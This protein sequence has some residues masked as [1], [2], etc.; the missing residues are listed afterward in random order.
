MLKSCF[1]PNSGRKPRL[2]SW[3]KYRKAR[4]YQSVDIRIIAD[5]AAL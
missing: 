2:A 3:D 5:A 1:G 4:E